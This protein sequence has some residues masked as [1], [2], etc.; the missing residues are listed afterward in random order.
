MAF[1]IWAVKEPALL[2]PKNS[3]V[4]APSSMTAV[5]ESIAD[6]LVDGNEAPALRC[7]YDSGIRLP[8][9]EVDGDE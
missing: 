2:L 9:V 7:P 4:L 3:P 8:G 1:L 6:G 5:M